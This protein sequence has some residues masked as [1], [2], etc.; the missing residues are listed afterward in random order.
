LEGIFWD[1]IFGEKFRGK[2]LRGNFGGNIL[3]GKFWREI[4]F[5]GRGSI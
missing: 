2:K 3:G 1:G 5:W 4:I